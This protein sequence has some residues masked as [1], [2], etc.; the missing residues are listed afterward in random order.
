MTK[1]GRRLGKR[2]KE[3]KR[4]GNQTQVVQNKPSKEFQGPCCVVPLK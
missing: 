4:G 2:W 3:T 1:G